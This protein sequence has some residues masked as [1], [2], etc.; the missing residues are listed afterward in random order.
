MMESPFTQRPSLRNSLAGHHSPRKS[1][2]TTKATTPSRSHLRR[3]FP[4]L[5]SQLQQQQHDLERR[6]QD[7]EE[8]ED[9]TH[10][11]TTPKED[12]PLSLTLTAAAA[13]GTTTR[14]S[15]PERNPVFKMPAALRRR[16][17]TPSIS[18]PKRQGGGLLSTLK[19][20]S[21]VEQQQQQPAVP[22]VLRTTETEYDVSPNRSVRLL[23]TPSSIH[24]GAAARRSISVTPSRSLQKQLLASRYLERPKSPPPS[25]S[26]FPLSPLNKY[27][28]I[29]SST[30]RQRSSL[31]YTT[32]AA[33][34][35]NEARNSRN[36][37]SSSTSATLDW[38]HKTASS[39]TV[40]TVAIEDGYEEGGGEEHGVDV[41]YLE[42]E[43]D[44]ELQSIQQE[45]LQVYAT[46]VEE[47]EVQE[48]VGHHYTTEQVEDYQHEEHDADLAGVEQVSEYLHRDDDDG[49]VEQ[50]V[51]EAIEAVEEQDVEGGVGEE[52][53]IQDRRISRG[54]T[55]QE[56]DEAEARLLEV[57]ESTTT[58]T[59]QLRGV[60]AHLQEF[61]SPET[62]A[63]LHDAI[64]VLE[65]QPLSRNERSVAHFQKPTAST[66]ARSV[67]GRSQR[68]GTTALSTSTSALKRSH[69]TTTTT[70][71][72][73]TAKPV[74]A[75]TTTNTTKPVP[76]NFS[77]RLDRL[78]R[79]YTPR[80]GASVSS[81]ASS[82]LLRSRGVG[83]D[84]RK[85]HEF[86]TSDGS[87]LTANSRIAGHHEERL[88]SVSRQGPFPSLESRKKQLEK[89]LAFGNMDYHAPISRKPLTEPKSPQLQ[90]KARAKPVTS[91]PYEDRVLQEIAA[92]NQPRANTVN[93]RIFESV[94][95]MGVPK[96]PKIPLTVPKSPSFTK[97]K[98]AP[99][100]SAIVVQYHSPTSSTRPQQRQVRRP[101]ILE[102]R[103]VSSAESAKRYQERQQ[104]QQ[105][106]Q[107]PPPPSQQKEKQKQQQYNEVEHVEDDAIEELSHHRRHV[108]PPPPP[109]VATRRKT[110]I[111]LTVP[112][113]FHLETEARGEL[114]RQQF[115]R[116]L[117]QWKAMDHAHRLHQRSL[118][119]SMAAHGPSSQHH[120]SSSNNN[121]SR[122]HVYKAFVPQKSTKPLTAPAGVTLHTDRRIEARRTFEQEM[123]QKQKL[124]QE[125]LAEK[126]R[127]DE[128]REQQELR[129]L[130]QQT[131]IHANPIRHYPPI[132]IQRSG[133]PLTVPRSPLIGEKRKW[134]SSEDPNLM[135]GASSSS[136]RLK[137]SRYEHLPEHEHIGAEAL[138][139]DGHQHQY[140]QHEEEVEEEEELVMP[141]QRRP[142]GRKSWLEAND[143]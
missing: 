64:T 119:S 49:Q 68:S 102:Q 39:N 74:R 124:V 97:R 108:P 60:Y 101:E 106:Q 125:M 45:D 7:V 90:T 114:H 43:Y 56:V 67:Y 91:L 103:L 29:S 63:K 10:V 26:P 15:L 38:I 47:P 89:T 139:H 9:Y 21:L 35:N 92:R 86:Q 115:E 99:L 71:T 143:L 27:S 48:E 122:T 80:L 57:A 73:T 98:P 25:S 54:S 132:T 37:N 79:K 96:L 136:A 61:F 121:S 72:T 137:R 138:V 110:P 18:Q 19:N 116:K 55:R 5:Q 16:S 52:S 53:N 112:Q 58:L 93:R 8:E 17:V 94:G 36:S 31:P 14:N 135:L 34:P 46:H 59:S 107:L 100:R 131:I 128:Y 105:Q 126:A 69:H 81:A 118:M 44:E 129:K 85:A 141:F 78:Q 11:S 70:T 113:P 32:A 104:Q 30:G 75:T 95:D 134:R 50:E 42:Q 142:M 20:R 127:E 62:E 41:R 33:V 23:A 120:G 88:L 83:Q 6:G 84:R 3:S 12:P 4:I 133:K 24:G 123:R 2:P 111:P 140:Q 22:V 87:T 1:L 109:P 28:S 66:L 82:N 51:A 76:F 65:S 117:Q 130:R 13:A 40:E 77:E